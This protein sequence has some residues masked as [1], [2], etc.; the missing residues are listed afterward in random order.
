MGIQ[1]TYNI[2]LILETVNGVEMQNGEVIHQIHQTG[3]SRRTIFL[4]Q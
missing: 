3:K 4:K 1:N 2:H